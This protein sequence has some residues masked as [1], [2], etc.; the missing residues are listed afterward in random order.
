MMIMTAWRRVTRFGASK[1]KTIKSL[2]EGDFIYRAAPS[3]SYLS[4]FS[5]YG[6]YKAMKVFTW[7]LLIPKYTTAADVFTTAK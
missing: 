1:K 7:V 4:T 6:Q 3:A 2:N 5:T